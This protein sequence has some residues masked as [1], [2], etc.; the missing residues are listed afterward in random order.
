MVD[1]NGDGNGDLVHVPESDSGTETLK[2]YHHKTA[3]RP[4]LIT[5]I[6]NGLEAETDI[7]YESLGVTD[8]Y[9]RHEQLHSTPGE[10]RCFPGWRLGASQLCWTVESTRRRSTPP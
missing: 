8:A 10:R 6:T 3:G 4:H 2:V 1:M 9:V 5:S 7:S